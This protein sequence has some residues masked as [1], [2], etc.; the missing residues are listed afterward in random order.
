MNT[1]S[2]A[3]HLIIVFLSISACISAQANSELNTLI[4]NRSKANLPEFFELLSIPNDS[5]VA[6]DIK[7]NVVWMSQA[8]DKRGFT[9]KELP[10][11]G[12]PMLYAEYKTKKANAKTVLFY[13]HLDGQPVFPEQWDQASPWIPVAK[14]KNADDK[15]EEIPRDVFFTQKIDPQSRVFGR[16]TADDKGPIMMFM[17]SIDIIQE[18]GLQNEINIK[19]ILDSEE[20]KGAPSISKIMNEHRQ[21]LA[22]DAIV[23][24]DGPMHSSNAPTLVFGNRG[25]AIATLT[26]YGPK[27]NLHSGHYGNYAPNP[28]QGLSRLITSMKDDD[29][30]VK[31][32]GYYDKIKLTAQDKKILASVPADEKAIKAR[33]GIATSEKVGDTLQEALQ[34]PSLNVRGMKAADIGVKSRT[35][36]P[37]EATAEFDLRTTVEA[38]G[39]Y[40]LKLLKQHVIKQGYYLVENTPSDEERVKYSKI[41]SL[42]S[43]KMTTPAARAQT[44]SDVANW[45]R[46]SL[47][48]AHSD[49]KASSIVQIRTMGGTIPTAQ[50]VEALN[51]P[52]IIIPMGNADNNQHSHNE[53]LR[54]GNFIDGVKGMIGLMTTRFN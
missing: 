43:P 5:T 11:N 19:L 3:V 27:E 13:M 17:T 12:K 36:I 22:A 47:N 46:K 24:H 40:L 26:V 50:I 6:A 4:E 8:L 34:Y 30:L 49:N 42:K 28:A 10:N 53:N 25:M 29:G 45:A 32:A 54:M 48:K 1:L 35:I 38:D 16:A 21:L 52:F 37:S 9:T 41:A 31:V 51:V 7:K 14:Q 15:W 33:I 2:R 23:I 39:N 44:D 18:A 20:E